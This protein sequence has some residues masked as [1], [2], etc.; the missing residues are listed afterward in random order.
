[1]IFDDDP[2]DPVQL[3][4]ESD[5]VD[6]GRKPRHTLRR[7]LSQRP[8]LWGSDDVQI[9]VGVCFDEQTL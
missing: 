3:H 2:N 8:L 7:V 4:R 1:M 9:D 5:N 6:V